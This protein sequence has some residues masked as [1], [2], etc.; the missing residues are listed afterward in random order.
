[1]ANYSNTG[2][3][4]L[5]HGLGGSYKTIPD[6]THDSFYN[7][8]RGSISTRNLKFNTDKNYYGSF[9]SISNKD[10]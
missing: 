6:R 1:M 3:D 7:Q 8:S 5:G 10:Q 9:N 4:L 2:N